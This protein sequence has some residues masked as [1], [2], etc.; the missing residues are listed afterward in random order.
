M[1][2]LPSW[3]ARSG[4]SRSMPVSSTATPTELASCPSRA[5]AASMRATPVGTDS[6]AASGVSAS[7]LTSRSGDTR[8]TSGS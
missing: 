1:Q 6:P 2:F 3:A 8:A 7:A 5:L 4:W